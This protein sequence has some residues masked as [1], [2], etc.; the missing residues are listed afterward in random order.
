MAK[1]LDKI[2]IHWTAGAPVP[3]AVD[4]E[5]YHFI[6][7]QEGKA[8]IGNYKP[9]DNINCKDGKYARHTGGGNT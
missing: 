8:H 9:E 2:I 3:N 5:H 1:G 4:K 7:D 6:I